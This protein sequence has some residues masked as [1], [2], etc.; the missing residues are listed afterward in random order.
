M[1]WCLNRNS[2][3]VISL[4]QPTDFDG[5]TDGIHRWVENLDLDSDTYRSL[6]DHRLKL[7]DN[8]LLFSNAPIAPVGVA[9]EY[10]SCT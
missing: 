5:P 4:G 3:E 8:P 7:T 1:H 6:L 2:V 10:G 9:M